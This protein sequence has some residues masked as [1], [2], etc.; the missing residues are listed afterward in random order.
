M[1]LKIQLSFKLAEKAMYEHVLK[2]LS[3]SIYLKQLLK[4]EIEKK[5]K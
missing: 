3:P 4:N 1:P 5:E 2:Q